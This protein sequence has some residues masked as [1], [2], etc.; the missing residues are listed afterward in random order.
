[1]LDW[2]NQSIGLLNEGRFRIVEPGPLHAPIH[3]FSIRRDENL[4]LVLEIEAALDAKSTAPRHPSGTLRFSTEQAKLVDVSG[5]T[6]ILSGIETHAVAQ[7]KGA[8]REVAT[9]HDLTVT[10]LDLRTAA[11]TIEWLENLPAKHLWPDTIRTVT[12]ETTTLSISLA[13]DGITLRES[14]GW[15]RSSSAAV[16]LAVAGHIFYACAPPPVD[17]SSTISSGYIVYAGVPDDATRKKIRVA[18]SFAFGVYL[19]ETG[20]TLYDPEWQIVSATSRSA[21]SLGRR[22]F[23]LVTMPLAPLTDRNFQFD[24]GRSKL[25]RMVDRLFFRV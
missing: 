22:A 9:V 4:A 19:V 15:V 11:Y 7:H 20:H 6:A 12:E 1:V 2:K 10:L 5:N 17:V 25:T 14:D 13:D 8:L 21:Y 24:I 23:D 16:R 3:R 18:L